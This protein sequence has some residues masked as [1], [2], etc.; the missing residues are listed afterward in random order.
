MNIVFLGIGANLGD[1]SSTLKNAISGIEEHIGPVLKSSSI[2]ETDPWGFEN[3]NK[4]LNM[5]VE[6]DTKL[7]PSGLLMAILMIESHLGRIRNEKQYSSRVIDIDILL[8]NEMVINKNNLK[9]PHPLMHERKFVLAPLCEIAP[10]M[11]HPVLKKSY[12]ELLTLC[13]DKN[14]VKLYR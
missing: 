1:R 14:E 3:A 13:K 10:D 5:V 4:F 11:V 12:S 8:Y 6:V 7:S 9:V 2:Y